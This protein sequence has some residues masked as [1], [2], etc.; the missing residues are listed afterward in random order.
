[1]VGL[2]YSSVND[3]GV[4]ALR[5]IAFMVRNGYREKPFGLDGFS[6]ILD[7]F[8][9]FLLLFWLSEQFISSFSLDFVFF[10]LLFCKWILQS[11]L[12]LPLG[13]WPL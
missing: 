9:C 1:M 5:R 2:D 10:V 4:A 3:V 11:P 12:F 8:S 7:H 13:R 6:N